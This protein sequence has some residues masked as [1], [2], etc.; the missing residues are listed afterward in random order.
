MPQRSRFYAW[1]AS[2]LTVQDMALLHHTREATVPRV[3]ISR[4]IAAG[5]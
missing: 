3:P 4:L 5:R 2:A 1:P